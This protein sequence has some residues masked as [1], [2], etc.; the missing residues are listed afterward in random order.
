MDDEP[1]LQIFYDRALLSLGHEAQITGDG[2]QAEEAFRCAIDSGESFDLAILDLTVPGAMGG[3]ETLARLRSINPDILAIVA[4]GYSND[5]DMAD[6]EQAGFQGALK[7]PFTVD[8]LGAVL[9][10]VLKLRD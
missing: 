7:K 1:A 8:D 6:Y 3:K 5:P 9:D 4:S 10:N 2:T